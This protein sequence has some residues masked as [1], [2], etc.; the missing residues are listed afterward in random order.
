MNT[1]EA[2]QLLEKYNNGQAAEAEVQLLQ[3]WLIHKATIDMPKV[4]EAYYAQLSASIRPSVILPT[5]PRKIK[6]WPRIAGI[7]A[8]I[9]GI[10]ICIW[11]FTTSR[12][13]DDSLSSRANANDLN[14]IA[15]GKNTAMLSI[16]NGKAITLSEAKSGVIIDATQ[17]K[18]NDGTAL[19]AAETKTLTITTPRGGTYQVRLPDGTNVWLNA[20]S[21]LTYASV[22]K[23]RGMERVVK[24]SGEAYFE[25]AKLTMSSL[26]GMESV[27]RS[28]LQERVPFIVQTPTQNLEVLGTH[29]N[30]NAYTD[31]GSVKTT[32]LEGSVK[33][34]TTQ[35][36]STPN[37][38]VVLKPNQESSLTGYVF[39]VGAADPGA[40][41]W[42]KGKFQF[43][44]TP[45]EQVMKQL[46]RWYD[47]E[48]IYPDGIPD[49]HFTGDM[50]RNLNASDVLEVLEMMHVKFKIEGKKI[51]VT[52]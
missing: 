23:E 17:I 3:Y 5:Q 37:Q 18:Y 10:T 44:D 48:I 34:S 42:V 38:T 51:I 40:T 14:D 8:A 29:F 52:K 13:P 6:L 2:R 49:E 9:I 41:A 31:E 27:S 22:L 4:D 16:N 30:V 7:A 47:V 19:S 20:A 11:L 39:N 43:N 1:T 12:H 36:K 24:L 26:R 15:P 25:V 32:L 45:M 35:A 21:S 46:A 50:K 28:N 33:L